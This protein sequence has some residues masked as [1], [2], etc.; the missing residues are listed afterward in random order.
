MLVEWDVSDPPAGKMN[1][2]H[3]LQII[4]DCYVEAGTGHEA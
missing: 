1:A 2:G 4:L 3:S